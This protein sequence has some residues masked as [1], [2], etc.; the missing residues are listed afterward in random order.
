MAYH[1]DVHCMQN[2]AQD[3]TKRKGQNE[4]E[5]KRRKEWTGRFA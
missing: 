4:I 5:V 3:E 2:I 1:D